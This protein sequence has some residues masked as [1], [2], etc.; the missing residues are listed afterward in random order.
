MDQKIIWIL[1]YIWLKEFISLGSLE[2]IPLENISS[3][4]EFSENEKEIIIIYWKSFLPWLF[5]ANKI[6][7][8]K[9]IWIVKFNWS[10]ILKP[11]NT[12]KIDEHFKLLHF[13]ISILKNIDPFN[14]WYSFIDVR[15]YELFLVDCKNEKYQTKFSSL[16]NIEELYSSVP[17][18]INWL[19]HIHIL[20]IEH[21]L[22]S[23][24]ETSFIFKFVN[25]VLWLESNY[26]DKINISHL[27]T[28]IKNI[29]NFY[30]KIKRIAKVF[31]ILSQQNLRPGYLTFI[32]TLLEVIFD[33]EPKTIG[34]KEFIIK[35]WK[36]LDEIL[37][38]DN[39]YYAT[40]WHWK[41]PEENLWLIARLFN[42]G[43]E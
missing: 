12:E 13:Y 24:D 30:E 16:H 10:F 22:K 1:P 28:R 4:D 38:N 5:N 23:F 35:K 3:I 15:C 19:T 14:Y 11:E 36:R 8:Y 6:E 20:P 40:T 29:P 26:F 27:H 43:L 31:F 18:N 9:W 37:V 2:I 39:F 7:A 32:P 41:K 42:K 33:V 34:K 21:A 25:Y 17:S